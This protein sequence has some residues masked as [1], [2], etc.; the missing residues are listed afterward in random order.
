MLEQYRPGTASGEASQNGKLPPLAADAYFKP[1]Q[2]VFQ[3]LG[4][5]IHQLI[6]VEGSL[7][8]PNIAPGRKKSVTEE[9]DALTDNLLSIAREEWRKSGVEIGADE[10][11]FSSLE[12]KARILG[13]LTE[14]FREALHERRAALDGFSIAA[15]VAPKRRARLARLKEILGK[16]ILGYL[17]K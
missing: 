15:H 5:A 12:E 17:T 2:L 16:P 9:I 11:G 10:Q 4:A 7:R 13:H 8:M 14:E 3:P 1:G 6:I